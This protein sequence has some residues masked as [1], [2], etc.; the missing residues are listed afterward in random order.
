MNLNDPPQWGN[1]LL[2]PRRGSGGRGIRA[3]DPCVPL[4]EEEKR[5]CYLQEQIGG[6]PVSAIYLGDDRRTRLLGLTMQLVGSR[7]LG[8]RMFQYAGSVGPL[9]TKPSLLSQ[10]H[11]LGRILGQRSKLRGLFGVDGILRNNEFWTIEVNP[12]YTSSVEVLEFATGQPL[13]ALHRGIFDRTAPAPRPFEPAGPC[14]G[15]AII[16]AQRDLAFPASGPWSGVLTSPPPATRLAPYADIPMPGTRIEEGH[17]I[18]TTLTAGLD[19][20]DCLTSLQHQVS[21]ILETLA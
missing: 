16:Y 11:H 12:R 2:K 7:Y 14:I 10:L 1:W 13:L 8:A 3:Y 18:L 5:T 4:T 6:I 20:D 21:S 15:K 17:P 9:P 19:V